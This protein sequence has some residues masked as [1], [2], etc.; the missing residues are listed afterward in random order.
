MIAI[1]NDILDLSKIEAGKIEV[2]LCLYAPL[3]IANE[4]CSLMQVRAD[5]KNIQ[6]ILEIKEAVPNQVLMDGPRVRQIL[7]NLIGNAIKFTEVGSVRL[8][9]RLNGSTP[10][11]LEFEVVDTGIGLT[12]H[13]QER[14]FQPFTQADSS[15]SRKFG[16]TGLGLAISKRLAEMMGGGLSILRSEPNVGTSFEAWIVA[17][18]SQMSQTSQTSRH[19]GDD[20][21]SVGHSRQK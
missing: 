7:I 10:N 8:I 4:V 9:V 13:Q 11:R 2:E 19:Q 17:Q 21:S 6:L 15:V 18:T 16:G 5:A 12:L 1:I 14:L 3:D 20:A